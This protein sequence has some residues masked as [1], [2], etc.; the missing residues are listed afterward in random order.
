MGDRI[1]CFVES[2]NDSIYLL[3][4]LGGSE[5]AAN[6]NCTIFLW[7]KSHSR[8]LYPL[9]IYPSKRIVFIK[10]SLLNGIRKQTQ[11][12]QRKTFQNNL[13]NIMIIHPESLLLAERFAVS[14]QNWKIQLYS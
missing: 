7:K 2:N 13:N 10:L 6:T 1:I 8:A 14:I 3:T 11:L 12:K 9:K 4:L 5:S